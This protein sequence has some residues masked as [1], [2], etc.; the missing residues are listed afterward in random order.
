MY[1][2]QREIQCERCYHIILLAIL[3][4]FL[5]HFILRYD[6]EHFYVNEFAKGIRLI[7]QSNPAGKL[8]DGPYYPLSEVHNAAEEFSVQH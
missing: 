2:R 5:P 7:S 4:H 6:T 3:F 1:K 8:L